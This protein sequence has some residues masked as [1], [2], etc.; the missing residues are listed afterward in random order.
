MGGT[1]AIPLRGLINAA[2]HLFCEEKTVDSISQARN[3]YRQRD[4]R[5]K[6][7]K[8]HGK[9][10]DCTFWG[11]NKAWFDPDFRQWN[12]EEYLPGIKVPMLANQGKND[13]YG[14]DAQIE[15]IER[16][17][18]LGAVILPQHDCGRCPHRDQE[19]VVLKAMTDFIS[20]L[21]PQKLC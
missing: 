21:F 10:T 14:S 6:L 15:S 8:Y 13:E 16:Q 17:A 20:D 18:D 7:A 3:I 9:N 4:L 2:A 5:L 12:L 11:W 19:E 1:T